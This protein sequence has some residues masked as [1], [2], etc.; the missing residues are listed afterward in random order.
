M[1]HN[2]RKVE[3]LNMA[4]KL[5][6]ERG[7]ARTSMRYLA[8]CVGMEAASL[9]NHIRSKE[10]ILSGICFSMSRRYESGMEDIVRRDTSAIEQLK[11]IIA[12]HV[13]LAL[14]FPNETEVM[15]SEWR[16]MLAEDQQRYRAQVSKYESQIIQ[17]IKRGMDEGL[18]AYAHPRILMYTMLSSFR[19]VGPWYNAARGI[20]KGEIKKTIQ[21]LIIMGISL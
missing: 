7:F 16:H 20:S 12:L 5:Y 21:D 14:D 3:I 18:I 11:S 13:E 9:Y 17:I 19:W 4:A 2:K 10:D 15:Q 1:K 6:R 8:Q